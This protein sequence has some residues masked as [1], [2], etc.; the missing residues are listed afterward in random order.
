MKK[1][2]FYLP[3]LLGAGLFFSSCEKQNQ[4]SSVNAV[5]ATPEKNDA[6]APCVAVY[7]QLVVDPSSG[8]SYMFKTTGSPTTGSPVLTP[9]I[10]SY[11]DNVIREAGTTIPITYVTGIALEPVSGT[12]SATTSPASS[13]PN[14]ILR[15]TI[16]N[17]SVAT[18]VPM[19]STCGLTLNVSDIEYNQTNGRYYAI[20]RGTVA[21]DNRI[22]R[23][24]PGAPT[25]IIC[26]AGT[27]AV[28]R[29]LRG[30]TFGCNGQGYVMQMSGPNGR[31][32]SFNL[33]N[34]NIGAPSCPYTGVIA[35][36]AP[37]ATFP[38]MGL[39]FDCSCSGLFITGNYDPTGGPFLLTDGMPACIGPASYASLNG[40]IKSTVDYARP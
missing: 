36:G 21:T 39:H 5:Q 12:V 10:G 24:N 26:L 11:G 40:V 38:E 14:K 29:Q 32:W 1:L 27:V 30:L 18:H 28:T 16:A 8:L 31:L 19:V 7:Y 34:G 15:F 20:N 9:I 2:F 6:V 17:P 22:V 35:P 4:P 33:A 25:N 13:H 37:A 23:V 3:F